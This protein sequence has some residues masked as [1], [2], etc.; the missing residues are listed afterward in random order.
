M[1]KIYTIG[2]NKS[3]SD[4]IGTQFIP[5][6]VLLDNELHEWVIENFK[7]EI[8]ILVIVLPVDL[9]QM[10]QLI[11][12]AL[13]L[14]LSLNELKDKALIPIVFTSTLTFNQV[15]VKAKSFSQI[16]GATGTYFITPDKL[17]LELNETKPILA[18][19]YRTGFLDVIN[20]HPEEA[21]GKHS[22]ANIWGAHALDKAAKTKVFD[23]ISSLNKQ[24]QHL[25]LKF[26]SAFNFD[27][28][29]LKPNMPN[30]VGSVT[31]GQPIKIDATN[32]KILLIDDEADKGWEQVLRKIFKT[33]KA[34]DFKV[35]IQKVKDYDAFSEENKN[36]I[37]HGKFDIF[38]IDLRLNGLVEEQDVDSR[39]FSGVKV[40]RKIK[41]LNRG[42]QTIIFTASN[43]T[44]NL[45]YLLDEGANGY[46]L[47]ESPEF[48]FS[49]KFSEKNYENF[50]SEVDAC[51]YYGFLRD[52]D[53][54]ISQCLTFIKSDKPSR[55]PSYQRFYDRA[56]SSLETGFTLLEKSYKKEKYLSLA[57]LAF[58]Q[59][60]ED[61]SNQEE[62]FC[63]DVHAK[64]YFADI[65]KL[66]IDINSNEWELEYKLKLGQ[67]G[68]GYFEVG[69]VI[70]EHTP[71][72]LAKFSFILNLKFSK[73][74]V[75]LFEWAE[76]NHLRNTKAGHGTENGE[77]ELPQVI[78]VLNLVKMILTN[79]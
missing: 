72:A 17:K 14:R 3:I 40:F 71:N 15:I 32:K 26:V 23:N 19:E 52:I 18:H 66:A 56:I 20:I 7:R 50:R 33:S 47:K 58:Y 70:S 67:N 74:N 59:I 35:I 57:F 39:D 27:M 24:H 62:N 37:E 45:K 64:G 21:I 25:Y 51:F 1:E 63:K 48:N 44:W 13:H 79:K 34:D 49:K 10:L 42:N 55:D 36:I 5:V 61:Y 78:N 41:T 16:F 22:L 68:F 54:T 29:L 12:I 46:Y 77:I 76:I 28:D 9:E 6:P 30:I 11:K 38:L 73:S 60:I 2:Y 4:L 53:L 31:L 8:N 43:K 69:K 65:D 75:S